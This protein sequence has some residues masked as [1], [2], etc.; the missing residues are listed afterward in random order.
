MGVLIIP[1]CRY[2]NWHQKAGKAC[3]KS[4]DNKGAK[5]TLNSKVHD[6]LDFQLPPSWGTN[7]D[8]LHRPRKRNLVLFHNSLGQ[9][10]TWQPCWGSMHLTDRCLVSIRIHLYPAISW[11]PPESL[12]LLSPWMRRWTQHNVQ[13]EHEFCWQGSNKAPKSAPELSALHILLK[14]HVRD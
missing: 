7:M 1:A 2:G 9:V 13:I 10:G 12:L 4:R 8:L 6:F 3:P 11:H 14:L 5:M